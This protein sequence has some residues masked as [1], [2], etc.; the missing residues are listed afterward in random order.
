M[1]DAVALQDRRE[2]DPARGG[3]PRLLERERRRLDALDLATALQPVVDEAQLCAEALPVDVD[4]VGVVVAHEELGQLAPHL[5]QPVLDH[6]RDLLAQLRRQR[7]QLRVEGHGA[8]AV[9][10]SRSAP[11]R[12]RSSHPLLLQVNGSSAR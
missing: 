6:R 4:E 1:G 12:R 11:M 2:L 9:W 7:P 8:A 5:L 3:H 10:L